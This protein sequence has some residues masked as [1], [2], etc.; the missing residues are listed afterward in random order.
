M[1]Q[2]KGYVQLI[3]I[4][5]FNCLPI[6]KNKI[7]MFSYYGSQY[8][9]NP[10]Y[11]TEYILNN[12]PKGK[13][14]IIW[15]FNK[16][17]DH[18]LDPQ[19]KKVKV[20]SLKYFYELCTSKVIIT[21]FRTTDLFVKRKNQY[22]IQT[23]HSSLRLKHIEKDAI[24]ILPENYVKMARRD[25]KKIDLLLSGCQYSTQ[26]FR[27]AFW[28]K[29]E[30][31]EQGTP[32]NDIFFYRQH[33]ESIRDKLNIPPESKVVLYAPTFRKN[34][35]LTA[36]DLNY[37][38]LKKTLQQ[39]FAGEWT[40]LVKFHPHLLSSK[41]RITEGNVIDVTPY[42]DVQELL[43]LSDVLITDYSSLMFDFTT[44]KRPCFLYVPDIKEYLNKERKLYFDVN[45]LPFILAASNSE[46]SKRIIEFNEE[47]YKG[48]L[49]SFFNQV[50][51][52][53]NGNASEK[54]VQ[55][56]H[57]VCFSEKGGQIYEAV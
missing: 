31:L 8:G 37:T 46:L 27:R 28:Y 14:E 11:I 20:M 17:N 9:C 54:V 30:I 2:L 38:Q 40:V 21:N 35:D 41:N 16:P 22:Y 49:Q 6:K 44:T 56:L 15:A 42:N 4:H 50:G 19:I 55:H 23:W 53:E 26:I 43:I 52:G 48:E 3:I 34:N 10:K 29:G 24:E 39:R 51:T 13:F 18:K 32:R 47:D 5:L 36:Y 1:N 57:H 7:F 25:S 12:I 33:I 45:E